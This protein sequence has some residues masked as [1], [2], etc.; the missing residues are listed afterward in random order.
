[1]FNITRLNKLFKIFARYYTKPNIDTMES[2]TRV[3]T[4]QGV[5][6]DNL[7]WW[8]FLVKPGIKKLGIQRYKE[9]NKGRREELNLLLLR[10]TE[11]PVHGQ[12]NHCGGQQHPGEEG[13]EHQVVFEAR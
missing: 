4:F 7:L 10:Q 11:E 8:E 1:M 13:Q 3:K 2:W 12:L 5:D 9:L 6:T